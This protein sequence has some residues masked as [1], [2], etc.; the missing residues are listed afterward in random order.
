ML[1]TKITIRSTPYQMTMINLISHHITNNQHPRSRHHIN[2]KSSLHPNNSISNHHMNSNNQR[3]FLKTMKKKLSKKNISR[4]L[5]NNTN[6]TSQ[7]KLN[8]LLKLLIHK[9][10]YNKVDTPTYHKMKITLME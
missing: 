3:M 7:L 10:N 9:V 6:Q 8:H 4:K 1:S 5:K 2:L